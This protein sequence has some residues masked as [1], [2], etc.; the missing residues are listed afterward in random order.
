MMFTRYAVLASLVLLVAA[1]AARAACG[2]PVFG[3]TRLDDPEPNGCT[4]EDCSL[5]EAVIATV[6]DGTCI[7]LPNGTVTL[8]RA[9]DGNPDSTAGSLVLG[10][11]VSL[12]GSGS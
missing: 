1:D 7:I 2:S 12:V 8:T 4:P 10:V 5:R 6:S 3:V 11:Q 9:D